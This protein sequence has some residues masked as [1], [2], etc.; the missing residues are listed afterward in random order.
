MPNTDVLE[1]TK[2]DIVDQLRQKVDVPLPPMYMIVYHNDNVTTCDFVA[3]TLIDFFGY[4][5]EEA[6][7]LT[8]IVDTMG[9]GVVANEL[10]LEIATHLRDL[11]VD[12]A[13]RSGFPL[14]VE[15]K[16]QN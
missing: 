11:V 16:S 2:V 1:R 9:Q 8:N 5:P 4:S 3:Q 7:M 12:R 14:Q 15:I 13:K 10:S 6:A